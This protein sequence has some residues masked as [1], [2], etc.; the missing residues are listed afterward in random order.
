MKC[1]ICQ[2]RNAVK[3]EPW[4][5]LSCLVCRKKMQGIVKP[6][7][8]GEV[9]TDQIK[10]DRK[11]FKKDI[12]QPWRDSHLSKEFVEAYP[13]K[14]KQMLKEKTATEEEVRNAKN[15]WTEEEYYKRE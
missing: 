8:T 2:K 10:E 7:I 13:D 11:I 1:L 6:K 14:V 5:Y 3:V 12:T 15:L 4:G 9:T